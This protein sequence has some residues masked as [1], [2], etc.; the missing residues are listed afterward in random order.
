ME[1]VREHRVEPTPFERCAFK[2]EC[3]L[4]YVLYPNLNNSAGL[5]CED[6]YIPSLCRFFFGNLDLLCK[7]FGAVAWVQFVLLAHVY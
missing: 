5:L 6:V 7:L 1:F 2:L 3:F 4:T